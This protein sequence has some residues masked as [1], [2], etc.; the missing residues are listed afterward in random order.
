MNMTKKQTNLPR[1]TFLLWKKGDNTSIEY[2]ALHRRRDFFVLEGTFVLLLQQL[3]AKV[4]Y[5]IV[6]DSSWR[7]KQVYVCHDSSGRISRLRLEVDGKQTWREGDTVIPFATGLFDVDFEI[8]PATNTL[9]IRRMQLRV[10]ESQESTAIWVRFPLLNPGPLQQRYTRL[11][12][13]CYAY[14]AP[15]LGFKAQ[16]EVD[17]SGLIVSYGDL[18]TRMG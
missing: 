6:C 4:T 7:T 11:S 8:S 1:Q 15:T 14:E 12:S 17:D 16:L 13:N 18:W 9:P 10:G 3:P 5:R 2:F